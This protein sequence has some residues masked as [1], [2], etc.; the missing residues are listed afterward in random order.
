MLTMPSIPP[1]RALVL[2]SG[3]SFPLL[4][5]VALRSALAAE[6]VLYATDFSEF[7]LGDDTLIGNDGWQSSHPNQSL[8]GTIDDVF[9][10]GNRSGTIGFNIPEGDANVITLW[11]PINVDPIANN[12]LINFSANVAVIDSDNDAYDSFYISVFNQQD[13]VLGSVIFDNTEEAFG[14]WRFD[15]EEFHD[16]L[17]P[18]EHFQVY[19]LELSIDFSANQ[20]SASLDGEDVA[21]FEN[22][23]LSDTNAVLNLGDIAVEWEVS[24]LNNSG[25][26]WFYFDDWTVTEVREGGPV[27]PGEAPSELTVRQRPNGSMAVRF[28][29][30]P[31]ASYVVEQGADLINWEVAGPDSTVVAGADGTAVYVDG[32]ASSVPV[33]YYRVR[34]SS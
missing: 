32:T 26:N 5:S 18:F 9:E 21:L 16:L 19:N 30:E 12:S 34:P 15:G 23:T 2:I 3:V 22:E 6:T 1:L 13:E 8:H 10:D 4:G 20:W 7:E 31:E 27:G 29:G 33:R 24:D 17:L 11:R 14:L 25:T 28:V